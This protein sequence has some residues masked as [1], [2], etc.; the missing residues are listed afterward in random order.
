MSHYQSEAPIAD[1][2]LL[3]QVRDATAALRKLN[4]RTRERRRHDDGGRDHKLSKVLVANRGEIAKRFFL[5]LHEEGIPSVAVVTEPDI[6]QSW[7]EFAD[8]T[9][10]I[11]DANN[12][13]HIP[14]IAAA[15]VLSGANA[16]YPGYGFL[17]ENVDFVDALGVC[18]REFQ[19]DIMFMGPPAS[20]MRKVG[21]K[22]DARALAKQNNVPVFEGSEKIRDLE[23]AAQEAARIGY[24]VLIKLDQGGG[25]KGM[26]PV[27]RESELTA[28]VESAQ[29][30]GN[31]LYDNDDYYL[32][33]LITRPVHIEVQIFNN[34]AVGIRKCAVQRRNQKIIEESGHSF[35]EPDRS[36]LL[37]EAAE[38]MADISGYSEGGGAGTVEFLYDAD[39]G[40]FGFLEMNTRLQV[41]Y[42][43][44][45]QSL[46]VDLA[47]WQVRYFD[48]RGCDLPVEVIRERRFQFDRIDHAIEC[49]IY[50]EDPENGYAPAPGK[51]V[52]LDLPT[53]NGVRCDFGFR[54]GDR[55]LPYYDPMI[56]KVIVRGS[57]R[58]QALMRLE[59]ALQELYIKGTLTNVAQLLRIVRHDAFREPDYTN[60]L[61][62]DY[63]ELE[64]GQESDPGDY[65]RRR[66]MA[67]RFGAFTEYVRSIRERAGEIAR[68]HDPE[69]ADQLP[70]KEEVRQVFLVEYGSSHYRVRFVQRSMSNFFVYINDEYS[71]RIGLGRIA[72]AEDEYLVRFGNRSLRI[73]TDDK[74][75]YTV[76]RIKDSDD[77]IHYYRMKIRAEGGDGD[78]DNLDLVRA[79]FQAT[80]VKFA[81]SASGGELAVG[82][83]VRKG[84]PLIVVSAMKMETTIYAGRD[85]RLTYLLENGDISKLQ[86]GKTSDGRI[87]GRSISEG[88]VLAIVDPEDEEDFDAVAVTEQ[89]AVG[90]RRRRAT[91]L[92]ETLYQKD[93]E[94]I[95]AEYPQRNLSRCLKIMDSVI[96]GYI[97]TSS[98]P[99]GFLEILENII[100]DRYEYE[101]RSVLRKQAIQIL[102]FYTRMRRLFSPIVVADISYRA[103]LQLFMAQKRL[104]DYKPSQNFQDVISPVLDAYN[105]RK[106][107]RDQEDQRIVLSH[108]YLYLHLANVNDKARRAITRCLV[109]M[110]ARSREQGAEIRE[111]LSALMQQ[112]MTELDES[113]VEYVRPLVHRIPDDVAEMRTLELFAEDD[114]TSGADLYKE[115][116]DKLHPLLVFDVEDVMSLVTGFSESLES[117]ETGELIPSEAPA[118]VQ[119]ELESKL[120]FLK[121]SSRVRRLYSPLETV[122]LYV[123]A[124]GDDR[125][126]VSFAAVDAASEQGAETPFARRIWKAIMDAVQVLFAARFIAKNPPLEIPRENGHR[127]EILTHVGDSRF[128]FSGFGGDFDYWELNRELTEHFPF[129]KITQ[130]EASILHLDVHARA[131]GTYSRRMIGFHGDGETIRFHLLDVDFRNPY[132]G[133]P[134]PEDPR[135]ERML[136]RDKWPIDFWVRECFD[137]VD[138]VQEILVPSIDDQQVV[139]PETGAKQRLVVG[140]SIFE[141]QIDGLPAIFFM[142][143]SRVRGGATGNLEGLKY[144]AA[145]YIAYRLGRPLYVWN[146]GA[147]ANIR[148]GVISLNRAAQGFMMNTLLAENVDAETFARYTE[149]NADE[150]LRNMLAEIGR[151]FQF[152]EFIA[153]DR[154]PL[155]TVAVGIGSSAG[156]DVYG[157]SQATLQ[158]LLDSPESYRVLTGS[159][160]IRSVTGE[161]LT[162]YEIGG[163]KIM[164]KWTGIADFI[165]RDK[166]HLIAI[167]RRIH[168]LF[169]AERERDRI[170]RK[171]GA[172][173]SDEVYT[174]T[175]LRGRSVV[176]ERILQQNV[177]DGDFWSLKDEYF[178]AGAVVGGFARLGGRR[179]LLLGTRSR[180]GVRSSATAIRARELLKIAARTKSARILI[181]GRRWFQEMGP[182]DRFEDRAGLRAR[183]DFLNTLRDTRG[184]HINILTHPDG[185]HRVELNASADALV[186]VRSGN[187]TREQLQAVRQYAA[188]IAS[189]FAGAFDY[190]QNL[191]ALLSPLGSRS[192]VGPAGPAN[193]PVEV[194]QAYDIVGSVIEA[195]CDN[196][197]FIEM[198]R[199]MNDPAAGPA[200]VTG[201]GRLDGRVVAILADQPQIMGGAPD[202]PGTE[203]FRVF[204]EL[205]NRRGLPVV[206]L[207]NAPGFVPG[208]RQERLRIQAIGAESLDVNILGRVPVVSVVLHQ[209]YGGRQIHAFSKF[210]RPGIAY[211]ALNS[212]LVAVMG[213]QAAYD[214]FEGRKHGE[215]LANGDEDGARENHRKFMEDFNRK[216]RADH[217][218]QESGLLDIGI[219][220]VTEL[221]ASVVKGMEQAIHSHQLAFGADDPGS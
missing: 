51:I 103:E 179:T 196:G 167:V 213:G 157:S 112:E 53:F 27:F 193:I 108:A 134:A 102:S 219:S 23:H 192:P 170:E 74:P 174:R 142:K 114:E 153:E 181:F 111:C 12:Y 194:N 156:L 106:H 212:S 9:V 94:S 195:I 143:D 65:D 99:D 119:S 55:V 68:R 217:D 32:E 118:W 18:S 24:P 25:G 15:A 104:G 109:H 137:D 17:S 36:R 135:V 209:N 127:V 6:G 107:V 5:A 41:E 64:S 90:R 171:G 159:N 98:L 115:A 91:S 178:A 162:N 29:R 220:D 78:E 136:A 169:G 197:S 67:V 89:P 4:R 50:A 154:P 206:M 149:R 204:M 177:D 46:G 76:L 57:D 122:Y 129:L 19:R 69:Q 60:R 205:V 20:V 123:L 97:P 73:R 138:S 58:A 200:L 61:L 117:D 126:L 187:E 39:T 131:S 141:G 87:L 147:G 34:L 82:T 208:T 190:A 214:L 166:I 128:D 1:A 79:P 180:F 66:I 105:Y 54:Q 175:A 45:D 185:L 203:K 125:R 148:E 163:A 31:D 42:A 100:E 43:V 26:Q 221:R 38:N 144:V 59:R 96:R 152:P 92:V 16:V 139:N 124:N 176:N 165:A 95:F 202:A 93:I 140:A 183:M 7:Y 160:V 210:L 110:L 120:K 72:D 21:N 35:L 155:F 88:E 101:V 85:G 216:S 14:T 133:L 146:D 184:V 37:L 186:Y 172:A 63:P 168:R 173:E 116:L 218:A 33:K 71:G 8:E 10:L 121:Q 13:T 215:L 28:A 80:F 164:G 2:P 132:S 198:Y 44:T 75:S 62:G 201:L 161:D 113:L 40:E 30:I 83:E 48:G 188:F 145:A 56:G 3:K 130:I 189:S 52:R 199:E 81:G 49:R 47:S 150:T 182:P 84:D 191:I 211:V 22:L 77:K 207:S 70:I 86:L 151:Q 158:V 11:G